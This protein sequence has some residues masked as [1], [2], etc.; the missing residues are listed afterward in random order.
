MSIYGYS[1]RECS[2]EGLLEMGEVTF[3]VSPD[4]LRRVARFL[5]HCADGMESG[6]WRGDHLHLSMVDRAWD[7]SECDV[8]VMHQSPDP[9]IRP[10]G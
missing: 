1:K 6:D 10:V 4:A 7:R 5:E 2:E 8:I 9:P 3:N